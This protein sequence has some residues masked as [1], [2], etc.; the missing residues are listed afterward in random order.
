[1][2][3]LINNDTSM[4]IIAILRRYFV[5]HPCSAIQE[6]S[7]SVMYSPASARVCVWSRCVSDASGADNRSIHLPFKCRSARASECLELVE[8]PAASST[9]DSATSCSAQ[10]GSDWCFGWCA[11]RSTRSSQ[12]LPVAFLQRVYLVIFLL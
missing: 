4:T 8:L 2:R 12:E 9:T 6:Q 1:M 5:R 10:G 7:I 3:Y 11:E